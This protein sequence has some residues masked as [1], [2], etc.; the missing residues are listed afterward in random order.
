MWN[1]GLDVSQSGIKTAGRNNNLTYADDSILMAESE[2]ELKSILM[3]VK[4]ESK[5]AGLKF[6]IQ[7]TKINFQ[8]KMVEEKDV[9][10][11]LARAPK[12]QLTIEQ[13][14]TGGHWNPSKKKKKNDSPHPKTKKK[15]Q[16]NGRRGTIMIKSNPIPTGWVIHQLENN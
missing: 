10:S 9:H 8:F 1:A 6:N 3:R 16:W 15:L 13:P 4:E 2:E 5:K 7:K 12:S 14:L 11:C